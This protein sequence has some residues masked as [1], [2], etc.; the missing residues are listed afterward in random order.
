MTKKDKLGDKH[1]IRQT[2]NQIML[3]N[4]LHSPNYHL[5]KVED[6][7]YPEVNET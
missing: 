4:S 7:K 2:K 1:T 6:G 3:I 5:W